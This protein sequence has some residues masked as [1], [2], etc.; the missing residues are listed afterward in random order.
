[1]KNNGPS[2]SIVGGLAWKF[3]E[4]IVSQGVAFLVSLVLA[5]LLSPEDYGVIALVLVF[6]NLA[7]VFITSGFATALI[8]KKDADDTDFSTIFYCSLLCSVLVYLVIFLIAPLVGAFYD[9]PLLTDVLRVFALQ[10][11]L[12]VF[13]SIQT[14]Y[15]SRHMLF[16]KVFF[17]TLI[18]A[19]VSGGVGI[20]MAYGGFGVWALVGQSIAMT[21]ANT[22]VMLF[23][24]PWRPRLLFSWESAKK[25]MKYSSRVLLADLSG[26]FF[27]EVRSLVI[28]RAYTS[29]DLAFYTKGQQLPNLITG[30]LSQ[31]IMTV[32]FPA[33]ANE[34]DNHAEV[35]RLAKKSLG[36]LSFVLFPALLG[37]AAVMEPLVTLLYT[38]KWAACV[39]YAQLLCVGSAVG[40]VGIV[41]VQTLKAV[42]RSDVVLGL[43]VWKKPVYM[44]LLVVGVSINVTAVAVTMVIYEVYGLTVNMLQLKKHIDLSFGEQLKAILPATVLAVVMAAVV[45]LLPPVFNVVV[46]VAVKVLVGMAVYLIAA[47]MLKLE[48][49]EYILNLVKRFLKK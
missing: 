29:A 48:S 43:E 19:A 38:E 6:I 41:P 15:V 22:L 23:I 45:W 49:L 25:M 9:D 1:M 13:N 4:R 46:T 31:S 27:G 34:S 20:G 11:P 47:A 37:L 36:V 33:M 44:L 35:K 16:R 14:A 12:G 39:P 26:T 30:N 10:V 21:L 17:S 5:R 28:G 2:N 32:L 24:V 18:S 40:V 7:G 8:Q 42:G 3:S